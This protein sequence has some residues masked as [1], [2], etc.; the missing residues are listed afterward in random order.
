MKELT[1][2]GQSKG[3]LKRCTPED[4][5]LKSECLV[6]AKLTIHIM[7][8]NEICINKGGGGIECT[9]RLN[10]SKSKSKKLSGFWN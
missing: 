4:M 10:D 7:E 9:F 3:F 2:D 1:L 8:Q 5:N 6:W